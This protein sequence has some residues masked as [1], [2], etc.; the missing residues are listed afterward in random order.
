VVPRAHQVHELTTRYSMARKQHRALK[1]ANVF[2]SQPFATLEF[3]PLYWWRNMKTY[4]PNIL[5]RSRQ[6][7]TYYA[8]LL[9]RPAVLRPAVR[10]YTAAQATAAASQAA[11][12]AAKPEN[13]LGSPASAHA[14]RGG[15]GGGGGG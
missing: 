7:N 4:M 11:V 2:I 1:A 15:G 3:P 6:L 10:T 8:R 12:A 5:E 14:Q 9:S 13:A